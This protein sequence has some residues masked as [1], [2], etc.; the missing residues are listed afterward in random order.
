MLRKLIIYLLEYFIKAHPI[1]V[2][3]VFNYIHPKVI[4]G[5]GYLEQIKNNTNVEAVF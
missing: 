5:I 2:Q 4:D 3:K 1:K